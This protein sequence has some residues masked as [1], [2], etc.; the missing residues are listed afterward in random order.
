MYQCDI[1][2]AGNQH[3]WRV[4]FYKHL[5]GYDVKLWGNPAPLWMNAGAVAGMHQGRGVSTT[6]TRFGRF[7]VQ[8]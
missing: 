7:A 6:T 3:S 2:T 4:A 1:T 8:G 5:A